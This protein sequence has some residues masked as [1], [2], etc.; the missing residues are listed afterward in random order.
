MRETDSPSGKTKGLSRRAFMSY[1]AALSVPAV[2]GTGTVS[3]EVAGKLGAPLAWPEFTVRRDIDE[4]F[5]KVRAIG[6]RLHPGSRRLTPLNFA[7]DYLLEFTLPPQHYAETALNYPSIPDVVSEAELA[8]VRL[9]SGTHSTLVFR[10]PSKSLRL[11]ASELLDWDNFEFL[12]PDPAGA[13]QDYELEVPRSIRDTFSRIDL[14]SGIEL[15][16]ATNEKL[17]ASGAPQPRRSGSWVELW[18]THIRAALPA[19]RASPIK[20]EIYSVSG[21]KRVS[22][23]GSLAQG[24]LV[25]TYA[26]ARATPLPVTALTD[27]DRARLAASLSRRFP[28]TGQVKPL[29]ASASIALRDENTSFPAAY[30]PGRSID[31]DLLL[32]SSRGGSLALHT[33]FKPYPGSTQAGWLHYACFGRDQFVEV[34]NEGFLYPFGTPCQLIIST[35]RIFTRDPTGRLVAPLNKQAFL[36]IA[37]PNKIH[38]GHLETP[39][40]SLSITT[41]KTAPLD[42]PPGGDPAEYEK[43]DYFIPMVAGAPVRFAHKGTD[44]SGTQHVADMPMVYVSN[45]ARARNGLVWEPGYPWQA[46]ADRL[47]DPS[48]MISV[49]RE[50]LRAV[51]R[52]WNEQP[53]R[54]VSYGAAIVELASANTKGEASAKLDWVEWARANVPDLD[55]DAVPDTPF[56]PRAR[57]MRIRNQATEHLSGEPTALL[58]TYRDTRFTD[59]PYLDPEPTTPPEDYF[60]NVPANADDAN[61]PFVFMLERRGLVAERAAPPDRM[62]SD[63]VSGI[64]NLYYKV[65]KAEAAP[66]DALFLGIDNEISFGRQ[67]SSDGVGGLTV[68]DTHANIINRRYGIVGDA[69]F[70]EHRWSGIAAAKPALEAAH[71]LDFAAFS[72]TRI[73]IDQTPFQE[74]R[75]AADRDRAIAAAR[76]LMGFAPIAPFAALAR[77]PSAASPFA[78]GLKLGDLFG[79]DAELIPGL[80]FSKLFDAI[81]LAG[82]DDSSAQPLAAGA[83]PGHAEPLSWNVQLSGI[84][85]LS[86]IQASGNAAAQLPV[87]LEQLGADPRED[88]TRRPISLGIEASLS[89]SNSRFDRKDLGPVSF[90]PVPGQTKISIE[91]LARID[92]GTPRITTDPPGLDFHPGSPTVTAKTEIFAFT[93]IIFEAIE[94]GFESVRFDIGSDGKKSFAVKLG[95]VKLL[96]ALDFINQIESMLK[97]LG[98]DSGIHVAITPQKAEI[99]QVLNFPVGG[100]SLPIGPALVT[101]L[102]FSWA[103]TIPLMGRDVLSV[104]FGLSSREKPMTIFVPPWYGGKAYALLEATTR[105][106]RLVEISMEYGALVPIDWA[107][108]RGEASL[109]AGLFFQLNRDGN[110]VTTVVL[111]AFVKASAHLSVAGIINFDGLI[112][113]SMT[114]Y[115]NIGSVSGDALVSVSIKIAFVR[116]S[117]SFTA[118]YDKGKEGGSS[119][120]A[121]RQS[122]AF[123]A[124]SSSAAIRSQGDGTVVAQKPYRASSAEAR[125]AFKRLLAEY[126][127]EGVAA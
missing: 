26:T 123:I 122:T 32:L 77:V 110:G 94:I 2:A 125:A 57:T 100:G 4:A 85:W 124:G 116:Y 64:R 111:T 106:C 17:G 79:R 84:E 31:V 65:S 72:Q 115:P 20:M 16:P 46:P 86:A 63:I 12:A 114:Y 118:H 28:D 62:P 9:V 107:I 117:Y 14:P 48:H 89:W 113:I 69:T 67:A 75:T 102:A 25:V 70:N 76:A 34:L 49:G 54:F 99:S 104:A 21:F 81:G 68:P 52:L 98:S 103:V 23:T 80:P 37:Q 19:H 40:R 55:P 30:A 88:P 11:R 105:G 112:Y 97:G 27:F 10:V 43:Y 92:L 78:P 101:N 13:A 71:R 56:R 66:P 41:E 24:T 6:F 83:D 44:W 8:S 51:D 18:S 87:L 73:A 96:G 95:D 35:Q 60:R 50:G 127:D 36:R 45:G 109:M 74:S 22:T 47:G 121:G 120:L 90:V 3:F 38:P 126:R 91:A 42:P 33:A 59:F 58:T 82:A 93:I 119:S 7:S 53:G 61:A 39:F 29:R 5:L 1:G 108:A 15:A